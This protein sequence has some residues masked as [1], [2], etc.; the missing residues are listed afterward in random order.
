M[1]LFLFQIANTHAKECDQ[2]SEDKGQYAENYITDY[3]RTVQKQ[4]IHFR[5]FHGRAR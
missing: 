3:G 4:K 1:L 2:D 5:S